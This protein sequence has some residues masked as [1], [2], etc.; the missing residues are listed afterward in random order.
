MLTEINNFHQ[1]EKQLMKKSYVLFIKHH[2]LFRVSI[3]LYSFCISNY[4]N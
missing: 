1:K 4:E 3:G 2:S